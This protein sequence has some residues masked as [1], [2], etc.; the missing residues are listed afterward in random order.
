MT[1][2]EFNDHWRYLCGFYQLV[3]SDEVFALFWETFHTVD[4]AHFQDALRAYTSEYTMRPP[5]VADLQ[6]KLTEQRHERE[7]VFFAAPIQ[8]PLA[9]RDKRL[10]RNALWLCQA[11]AGHEISRAQAIARCQT[12]A[13][14]DAENADMYA[15]MIASIEQAAF[16]LARRRAAPAA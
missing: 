7:R 12:W 1:K 15:E 5:S 13:R 2:T 4:S 9:P 14:E 8:A 11:L 6:A 10:A 16:E 3:L